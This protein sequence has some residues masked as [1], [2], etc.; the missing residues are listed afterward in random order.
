MKTFR[1][2]ILFPKQMIKEIEEYRDNNMFT[3]FTSA[4]LDLIRKGLKS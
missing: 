2:Q 1:K 4:L 3:T